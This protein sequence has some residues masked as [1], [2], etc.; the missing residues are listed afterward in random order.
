MAYFASKS[1]LIIIA[2]ILVMTF[3]GYAD[4]G[5]AQA[6]LNIPPPQTSEYNGSLKD[7]PIIKW[8]QFFVNLLSVIIIAGSVVMIAVAGVQYTASRD[9]AQ[10]TQKAKERIFN[11]FLGLV[12]FFFFYGFIQWL[13]PGGV[14]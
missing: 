14:F 9:N 10:G 5:V 6:D 8:I 1:N 2:L 7:N 12:A 13:I 11:V 4:M 3:V